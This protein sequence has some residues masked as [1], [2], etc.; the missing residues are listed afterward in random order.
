MK[1]MMSIA[2][3]AFCGAVLEDGIESLNTVGYLENSLPSGVTA[4]GVPF[5]T[6]ASANIALNDLVPKIGTAVADDATFSLRYYDRTKGGYYILDWYATLYDSEWN[7]TGASGWGEGYQEKAECK[8]KVFAPG[9][10]FLIA[11]VAGLSGT[12]K[13]TFPNPFW[14]GTL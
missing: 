10:G 11:P 2:L 3:A 7:P 13:L 1:K 4:S 5:E 8:D 9:E 12:T 6:T 14:D